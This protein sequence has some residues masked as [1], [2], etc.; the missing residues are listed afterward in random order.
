MSV[1]FDDGIECLEK[2]GKL[3]DFSPKTRNRYSWKMV[4]GCMVERVDF[5]FV[6]VV[7]GN[8]KIGFDF[9]EFVSYLADECLYGDSFLE[10]GFKIFIRTSQFI[11]RL[12]ILKFLCFF[13]QLGQLE[14]CGLDVEIRVIQF[15]GN[16]G[17]LGLEG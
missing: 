15:L 17:R 13:F 4:D 9:E 14:S 5:G 11:L 12:D 1:G 6:V 10:F 8:D 16:A 2:G 3:L 7:F